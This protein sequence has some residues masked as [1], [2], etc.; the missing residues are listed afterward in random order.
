MIFVREYTTTRLLTQFGDNARDPLFYR[1]FDGQTKPNSRH[2][3]RHTEQKFR[4]H[5]KHNIP[6]CELIHLHFTKHKY[7]TITWQVK[8]HI[9]CIRR[10]TDITRDLHGLARF[11]RMDVTDLFFRENL[12]FHSSGDT[13]PN[14]KICQASWR[15]KSG[16]LAY[17]I[18]QHHPCAVT[19]LDIPTDPWKNQALFHMKYISLHMFLSGY[20]V[21]IQQ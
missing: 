7:P 1:R 19:A 8:I 18:F 5:S 9:T 11:S 21:Q 20:H 3:K 15:W 6:T 17:W 12:Q 14:H 16:Q 10:T 2:R 13:K 4:E